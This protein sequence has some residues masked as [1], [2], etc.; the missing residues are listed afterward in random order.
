METL[1]K[2]LPDDDDDDDWLVREINEAPV[3]E[4]SEPTGVEALLWLLPR[5]LELIDE[6]VAARAKFDDILLRYSLGLM[7]VPS[8]G[9]A[10]NWGGTKAAMAWGREGCGFALGR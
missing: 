9:G 7:L 10:E 4:D 6:T 5:P 3:D 1:S 2:C 8:S